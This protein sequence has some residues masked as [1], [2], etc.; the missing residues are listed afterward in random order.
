MWWVCGDHDGSK[1]DLKVYK[2]ELNMLKILPIIPSS[3][4]QNITHY[5][6]LI[7]LPIIP[8]YIVYA[9][10]FQVLTSRVTSI[11]GHDMYFVVVIV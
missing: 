1:E 4:S 11:Y 3:T 2:P 7:S 10:L 9:L 8:N 5:S 6:I